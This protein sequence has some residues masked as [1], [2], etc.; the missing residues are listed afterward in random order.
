M[1]SRGLLEVVDSAGSNVV[2]S[3]W[4]VFG[5]VT[6]SVEAGLGVVVV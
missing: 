1:L 6:G 4:I 2:F 3:G 5:I